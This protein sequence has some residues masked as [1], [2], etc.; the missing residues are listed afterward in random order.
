MGA[1]QRSVHLTC[2]GG[3]DR[4]EPFRDRCRRGG[5]GAR[6]HEVVCT[7]CGD[8]I[9]PALGVTVH[10]DCARP[11]RS[12]SVNDSQKLGGLAVRPRRQQLCTSTGRFTSKDCADPYIGCL[13]RQARVGLAINIS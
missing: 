12:Q 1:G 5:A 2:A 8:G 3:Y 9:N 6:P 13:P 11:L 4:V 10:Y 7:G